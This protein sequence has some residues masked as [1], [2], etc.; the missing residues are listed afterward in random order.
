MSWIT[1]TARLAVQVHGPSCICRPC[2]SQWP[3]TAEQ[4]CRNC[5][6][7]FHVQTLVRLM[8]I[9]PNSGIQG[10]GK[11]YWVRNELEEGSS[12]EPDDPL[13][14][15]H[16]FLYI[17]CSQKTE[18]VLTSLLP[19]YAFILAMMPTRVIARKSEQRAFTHWD[20]YP[21]KTVIVAYLKLR[22]HKVTTCVVITVL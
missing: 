16:M 15:Y 5:L 14:R 19:L 22:W 20:I 6:L 11:R 10:F 17:F 4:G 1:A 8:A 21:S 12:D 3:R 13:Q 7:N 9:E 18:W 2:R